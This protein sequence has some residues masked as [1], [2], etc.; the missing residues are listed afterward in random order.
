MKQSYQHSN[1]VTRTSVLHTSD[2]T[3]TLVVDPFSRMPHWII[4]HPPST[5]QNAEEKQALSNDITSIYTRPGVAMPAFYVVVTFIPVP[6]ED[7]FVGGQLAIKRGK[8]FIR[9]VIT[10]I[11][12]RMPENDKVYADM[13]DRV[14]AVLKPYIANKGYDWE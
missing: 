13:T 3:T 1:F 11:H 2:S 8:P 9:L 6:D 14:D 7:Q 5:F 12:I 4:Y 10:H